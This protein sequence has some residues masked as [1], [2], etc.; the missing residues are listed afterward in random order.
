MISNTD[1]S[2]FC[3]AVF[4]RYSQGTS[5]LQPLSTKKSAIWEPNEQWSWTLDHVFGYDGVI[6]ASPMSH[7]AQFRVFHSPLSPL[8]D[9]FGACQTRAAL[10]ATVC[11][12]VYIV[13]PGDTPELLHQALVNTPEPPEMLILAIP[14]TNTE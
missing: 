2:R 9:E 6:G 14:S 5:H 11:R 13:Q 7:F 3:N 8:D 1:C 12:I 10:L 4:R